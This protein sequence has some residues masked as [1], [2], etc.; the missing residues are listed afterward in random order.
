MGDLINH[1]GDNG[2]PLYDLLTAYQ[3]ADQQRNVCTM[4][5]RYG[6]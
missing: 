5:K 1:P 3:H 4:S 6:H 2:T